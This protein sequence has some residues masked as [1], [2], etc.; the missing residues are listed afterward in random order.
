MSDNEGVPTQTPVTK[1]C[2]SCG[3]SLMAAAGGCHFCGYSFNGNVPG[4]AVVQHGPL[5]GNGV[6]IVDL[7]KQ[8]ALNALTLDERGYIVVALLQVVFGA[9][10]I[11]AAMLGVFGETGK[12]YYGIEGGFTLFLG[13]GLYFQQTWAQF[14]GKWLGI[15]GAIS[16]FFGM[17]TGLMLMS[18]FGP[19][20]F[21]L[22]AFNFAL[23]A[24]MVYFIVKVGDV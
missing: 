10:G 11:A 9:I 2:P 24:A 3:K 14:L 8:K 18:K 7:K 1:Q 13:L 6:H 22:N 12:A 5:S 4:R 19:L 17:L 15:L 20:S 21:L 16:G 23:D